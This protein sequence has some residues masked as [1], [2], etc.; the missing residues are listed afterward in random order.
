MPCRHR[1]GQVVPFHSGLQGHAGMIGNGLRYLGIR[2]QGRRAH[3]IPPHQTERLPRR[4]LNP[5]RHQ[6]ST[7]A[8][9][10]PRGDFRRIVVRKW[11][12]E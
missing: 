9:R 7:L 12:L 8:W 1:S 5:R 6:H 2:R 4:T 11:F 10:I 3:G